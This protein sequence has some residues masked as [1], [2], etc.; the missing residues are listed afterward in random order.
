LPWMHKSWFDIFHIS[1]RMCNMNP[2]VDN[3]WNWLVDLQVMHET[4][5]CS[6]ECIIGA[7]ITFEFQCQCKL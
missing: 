4:L 6:F 1:Y 3:H 2:F 5:L 7:C